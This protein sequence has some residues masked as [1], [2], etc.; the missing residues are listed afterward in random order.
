MSLFKPI[1]ILHAKYK[2]AILPFLNTYMSLK[3][4]VIM[5]GQV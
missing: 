1:V 5:V 4:K 3:V 2:A